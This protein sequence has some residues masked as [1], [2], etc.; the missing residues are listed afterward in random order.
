MDKYFILKYYGWILHNENTKIVLQETL[1]MS[2]NV[3]VIS[4]KIYYD[5]FSRSLPK[6][7]YMYIS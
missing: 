4:P 3:D 6:E 1:P 2:P 7:T 5:Y